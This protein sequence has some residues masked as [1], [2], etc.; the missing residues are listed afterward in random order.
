MKHIVE[1]TF[2]T[3]LNVQADADVTTFGKNFPTHLTPSSTPAFLQSCPASLVI[4]G[5]HA[6]ANIQQ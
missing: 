4:A 3:Q 1:L 5:T 2:D 6:T